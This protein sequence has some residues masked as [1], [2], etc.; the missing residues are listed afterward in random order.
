MLKIIFVISIIMVIGISTN[1]AHSQEIGLSTF[2]ES[3]QVIIDKK[4]SN[5]SI[6][7]ITLLSSNL[8]EIKIPTELE[9]KIRE[10][11][12]VQAVV[13]TNQNNCVLG[14]RD[15]ESCIIINIERNPE[16]K[17]INAIQDSTREIADLYIHEMN[18]V[19]DT[20]AKFFQTYIH[21][22]D[23]TNQALGTSGIISGY[24]TIS[25]VYTMPMQDTDYMYDKLSTMLLSKSI[26]D[27]E[28]FYNVAKIL[29][30]DENAKMSFSIIPSESKSLLQLR[31]SIENP[32]ESQMEETITKINPLEF[33][34]IEN[35]NR[36]DYFSPGNYPLNSI[37]QIV[38]LANDE[39]N[40]SDVRGNIIPTQ[41][42]DGIEI[43][44]EITKKGWVFDPQK[45]EQIQGKYIFGE[46][47]SINENELKFS[48]G[49]S[50]LQYKEEIKL[51]ESITVV[52]IITI[53]SIGAAIFYLKGYK[54]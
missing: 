25:A 9:Q 24:R 31:I 42:I 27:G 37:F 5:T 21:T 29:S 53:I 48:L 13:I 34:N 50:N 47:T 30:E 22:S 26:R 49:G 8:Q 38:I 20:N 11:E 7:S 10:N 6:T 23:E 28:G 41:M 2:Q 17:G 16:D 3:A 44:I 51:D 4:I 43:P 36:S 46:S 1:Y 12:R 40:V 45:G 32:I 15:Y 35:L 18:Q 19:F 14:V 54:K 33:F 52:I 39:M